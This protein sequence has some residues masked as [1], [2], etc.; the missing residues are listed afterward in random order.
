MKKL[1]R[2]LFDLN[3]SEFFEYAIE[4]LFGS[5]PNK[6]S[7]N[8]VSVLR[9]QRTKVE[10]WFMWQAFVLQRRL[11]NNPKDATMIMG[12]L[13]QIKVMLHMLAGGTV[14]DELAPDTSPAA[15][16]AADRLRKETEAHAKELEGITAFKNGPK[17]VEEAK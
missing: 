5:V 12:M 4:D 16:A 14:T 7:D 10:K 6:V 3:K 9:E 13:L 11:V 15:K 8:G 17:K 1:N 2:I